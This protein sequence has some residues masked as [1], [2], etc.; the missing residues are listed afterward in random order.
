[1]YLWTMYLTQHITYH[2]GKAV[3]LLGVI[4]DDSLVIKD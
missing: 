2:A 3:E 1:M 4:H